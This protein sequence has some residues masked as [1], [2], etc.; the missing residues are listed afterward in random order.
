MSASL[1]ISV[2]F[3]SL[4]ISAE[5][6]PYATILKIVGNVKLSGARTQEKAVLK[7]G[8]TIEVAPGSSY[9][10]LIFNQ[11][12]FRVLG[13]KFM[14]EKNINKSKG[15]RIKFKLVKGEVFF[16]F[17]KPNYKENIRLT[18]GKVDLVFADL[19]NQKT[20]PEAKFLFSHDG[21]TTKLFVEKGRVLVQK[22]INKSDQDY[23]ESGKM[24]SL[25]KE[26]PDIKKVLID[27]RQKT[28]LERIFS[29]IQE[30]MNLSS[31]TT[32]K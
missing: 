19:D 22:R 1:L 16:W 18:T 30:K 17:T 13:G 27:E 12:H 3:P 21:K 28:R 29:E 10:D 11:H 14:L 2:L 15:K 6:L 7:V 9:A 4:S 5:A 20:N 25:S 32:K 23:I 8:D 26:T 24:I 31:S